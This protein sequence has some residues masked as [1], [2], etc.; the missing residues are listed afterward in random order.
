[1]PAPAVRLLKADYIRDI[2]HAHKM[3]KPRYFA[4]D[5][6][7]YARYSSFMPTTDNLPTAASFLTEIER[8]LAKSGMSDTAFGRAA[9][10][11]SKFV[12]RLRDSLRR[13]VGDVKLARVKQIRAFM[14]VKKTHK[15]S[16]VRDVLTINDRRIAA[17]IKDDSPER[18][19]VIRVWRARGVSM[20]AIGREFGISRER[21]RQIIDPEVKTKP[22]A[23]KRGRRAHIEARKQEAAE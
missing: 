8:F 11:N 9:C 16:L 20:A 13:G 6:W 5:A 22:A 15:P 21:T 12:T 17:A 14:K 7:A 23:R 18:D 4:V 2:C 1:M 3:N 19:A 10:E